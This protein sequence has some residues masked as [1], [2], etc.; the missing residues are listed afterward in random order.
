MTIRPIY[1]TKHVQVEATQGEVDALKNLYAAVRGVL[2]KARYLIEGSE[3]LKALS[4]AEDRAP[5]I[6][7]LPVPGRPK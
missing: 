2:L 4:T 5:E 6:I 1:Q 7:E 3:E